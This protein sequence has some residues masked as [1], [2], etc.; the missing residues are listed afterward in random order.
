M[1]LCYLLISQQISK[2]NAILEYNTSLARMQHETGEWFDEDVYEENVA[3][4]I[5]GGESYSREG[6]L[7][8][9]VALE[10]F[11]VSTKTTTTSCNVKRDP[12]IQ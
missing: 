8:T 1:L 12:G 10:M 3:V 2:L 6:C 4:Q 9:Y 11:S 5:S 7:I